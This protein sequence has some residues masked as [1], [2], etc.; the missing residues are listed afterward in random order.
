MTAFSPASCS[1]SAP[2]EVAYRYC[3]CELDTIA[4]P[5]SAA[6][7]DFFYS[8]LFEVAANANESSEPEVLQQ[9]REA[10]QSSP[11]GKALAMLAQP[12]R[13]REATEVLAQ[14]IHLSGTAYAEGYPGQHPERLRSW[15]RE[16]LMNI[17]SWMRTLKLP[18][19]AA[20]VVE[21][22]VFAC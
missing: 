6:I 16:E 19:A 20:D 11:E 5:S 12:S 21:D 13:I 14:R 22:A 4:L 17:D 7:K 15:F 3:D 1:F 10:I 8:R 18:V 2:R 9:L